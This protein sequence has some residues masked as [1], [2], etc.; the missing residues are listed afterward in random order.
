MDEFIKEQYRTISLDQAILLDKLE[1][2]ESC[3][4]YY[5]KSGELFLYSSGLQSL[6][7]NKENV[8]SAPSYYILFV[9][10]KKRG[11]DLRIYLK[12]GDDIYAIPDNKLKKYCII[13]RK[14]NWN[15]EILWETPELYTWPDGIKI[16]V[17]QALGLLGINLLFIRIK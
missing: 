8:I 13:L 14:R 10:L 9:W 16:L 4:G 3:E 6:P 12:P 15:K 5:D 2:S 17:D 1:F 7:F 11:L